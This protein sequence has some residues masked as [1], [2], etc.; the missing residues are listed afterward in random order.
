MRRIAFLSLVL[1]AAAASGQNLIVN[2]DFDLDPT[3]PGNGWTAIGTGIL[4][5][6]EGTGDPDPPSARTGQS[7][8]ESMILCQCVEILGGRTYDFSARSYTHASIGSSSNG[9]SL[10][11]YESVDCSGSPIETTF[12]D[13]ESYPDW[14]LREYVGYISPPNALSARIEL[15]SDANGD[16]DDVS[17]DSVKLAAQPLAAEPSTWGGIKAL[18]R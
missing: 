5:W 14:A 16:I 15:H 11:V 2:P 17:W 6:N 4:S 13:L 1:F 10:S 9:V 18:Y 8:T 3:I 12:T 7:D